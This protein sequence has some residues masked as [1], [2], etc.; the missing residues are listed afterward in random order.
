M[1]FA[2]DGIGFIKGGVNGFSIDRQVFSMLNE[3]WLLPVKLEP[4]GLGIPGFVLLCLFP[5]W[6]FGVGP[7]EF[8]ARNALLGLLLKGLYLIAFRSGG[9]IEDP[10][11]IDV[12]PSIVNKSPVILESLVTRQGREPIGNACIGLDVRNS[13]IDSLQGCPGIDRNKRGQAPFL[14]VL[15]IRWFQGRSSGGRMKFLLLKR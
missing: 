15:G 11:N 4:P 5:S 6:N 14:I 13:R 9:G 10:L 8:E 7:E 2:D 3:F 12:D 1:G